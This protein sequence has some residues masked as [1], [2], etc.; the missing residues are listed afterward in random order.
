MVPI[1]A[2]TAGRELMERASRMQSMQLRKSAKLTFVIMH[3]ITS[4]YERSFLSL[5]LEASLCVAFDADW[6]A[7]PAYEKI[8]E[9]NVVFSNSIIF[10]SYFSFLMYSLY[11]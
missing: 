6:S 7:P 4:E 10:C 9:E 3:V 1:A 2:S 5:I 11:L 8:N